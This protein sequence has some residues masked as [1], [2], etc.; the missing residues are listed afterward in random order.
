MS[1]ESSSLTIISSRPESAWQYVNPL[2]MIRNLWA[3]RDLLRQLTVREVMGRYKG[4]YLGFLWSLLTPLFTLMVYTFV[5]SVIFKATWGVSPSESRA[6]FALTLFCGL[7]AFN[8]FSECLNR[9]PGLI[10]SS[11]NYVKRVVF[12]LEI[13]PLSVLG[14]ALIHSLMSL[15]VLCLG[16]LVFVGAIR[17]TVIYLPLVYLP[18]IGLCLGLSWFLASLGV[19]IRDTGYLVGVALQVL[20]FM[21]PIIYPISSVPTV[22]QLALRLNPLSSI[23]EDFRRVMMWGRAPDWPW[24]GAMTLLSGLVTVAGYVW[25]MKLKRAFADVV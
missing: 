16:I 19:F 8:V 5:F 6:E 10:V 20:F 14:A 11:P 23:V 2:T 22:L 9:A 25:F 24:W 3:Q 15:V 13:L 4:S 21:T 1:A 17:W 18:L 7:I 12:P